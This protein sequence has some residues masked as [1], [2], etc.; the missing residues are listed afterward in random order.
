MFVEAN[1]CHSGLVAADEN[2]ASFL[3]AQRL[4]TVHEG[5]RGGF[6]KSRNK[7]ETPELVATPSGVGCPK[8][9]LVI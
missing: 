3:G 4:W 6:R 8:L 7:Q 1:K 5:K 2:P 9:Q